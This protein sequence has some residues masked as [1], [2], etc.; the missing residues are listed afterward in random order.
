M[1]KVY[2]SGRVSGLPYEEVKA[3]FEA[4]ALH[5][6]YE[7]Y[8]PIIPLVD[9]AKDSEWVRLIQ[10][11]MDLLSKCDG[12]YMIDGWNRS[13]GAQIEYLVATKLGLFIIEES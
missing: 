6:R 7:N 11:S 4:A 13:F 9:G 2:I 3:K 8:E 1:K 12:I 5:L 10:R